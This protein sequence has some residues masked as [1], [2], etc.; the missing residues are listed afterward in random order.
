[1]TIFLFQNRKGFFG[2]YKLKRSSVILFLAAGLFLAL[3]ISLLVDFEPSEEAKQ[4]YLKPTN[5]IAVT[6]FLTGG[7][8]PTHT[9]RPRPPLH[10]SIRPDPSGRPTEAPVVNSY[11]PTFIPYV[12]PHTPNSTEPIAPPQPVEGNFVYAQGEMLEQSEK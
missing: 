4:E 6:T 3:L 5:P 8:I 9:R 10:S 11:R 2:G 12:E 1:M 7:V